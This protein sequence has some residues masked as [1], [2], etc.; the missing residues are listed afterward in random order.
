MP[1]RMAKRENM[2]HTFFG[3]NSKFLSLIV[4]ALVCAVIFC[5][6]GVS[7]GNGD[8][9]S[10]GGDN[11][12]AANIYAVVVN[13][14]NIS[15]IDHAT[16]LA[17]YLTEMTDNEYKV[18]SV[19]EIHDNY[20]DASVFI[21]IGN[22]GFGNSTLQT[23]VTKLGADGYS[24]KSD[25]S[26]VYINGNSDRAILYGIYAFLRYEGCE[27]YSKDCE[28]IPKVSDLK[29]DKLNVVEEP[30]VNI[31]HYLSWDT[32]YDHTDGTF[33][34]KSLM[35]S[36]YGFLGKGNGET[37]TFGY[38]GAD[39]HNARFYVGEEYWGTEY[40]PSNDAAVGGYVPCLTN[41][42]EYNTNKKSTLSLVTESMRELIV[43]NTETE[44]FTFEQEDGHDGAYCT[45]E[46]CVKAAKKYGRSGM[47]V[48]FCN[49]L[50]KNLRADTQL[51]GRK[52]K[53]VTFAYE[54]TKEPPKNGVTV[55][56]DLCIWYADYSDMRYSLTDERQ[57]DSYKNNLKSWLNLTKGEDNGALMIW[58]YDISYNNYLS[59]FGT[60][61]SAI[62][63]II[64]E[65]S[66]AGA[67]MLLVLGAYDAEN[68]W[69]SI[70]RSFIWTKKAADKT[71]KAIDLRNEFI[72]N[73]F[74]KTAG[75]Y[76]KKYCDAY[77]G[78]YADN[79]NY[80]PVRHGNE[81]L[82]DISATQH[83]ESL[84]FVND[85][86]AAVEA[87]KTLKTSERNRY[88]E[89]L[90]GVKASSYCS[91]LYY[92]DAYFAAATDAQ[93]IALFGSGNITNAA[94]KANFTE[95]F[96]TLC[97]NAGI[98]RCREGTDANNTVEDFVA[99][100]IGKKF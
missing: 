71:L 38:L 76:V 77:D 43:K 97:K 82:H 36:S 86:I 58:L 12:P 32:C 5:S 54:Y 92:F 100:N 56:K 39:T 60:S 2:V 66:D 7:D 55:D 69:Q 91:V 42:V 41:G 93:K 87:D 88:L 62:D 40:C 28:Y 70:M 3:E 72:D 23:A 31:R 48:R 33:T 65:I 44:Y 29:L 18:Y 59:Y 17:E 9:S 90:Y 98:T 67:E 84:S 20:T 37:V 99:N 80:Y 57:L 78:Y 27:F 74:G 35:N 89:R 1:I 25:G 13:N 53:I 15:I 83:V 22:S 24:L 52:F 49:E 21:S 73:Y 95:E 61:M 45:C 26:I 14:K 96:K 16:A 30:D 75:E 19:A 63:A 68:I 4:L 11:T 34:V 64:D 79:P 47:L 50:I 8:S 46:H 10:S 94:A 51:S 81:Y 85:A 6:C